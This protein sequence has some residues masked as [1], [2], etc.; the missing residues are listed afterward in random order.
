MLKAFVGK[1]TFPSLSTVLIQRAK[2]ISV[3]LSSRFAYVPENGIIFADLTPV[4]QI[5]KKEKQ[6][7]MLHNIFRPEI[8]ELTK[9]TDLEFV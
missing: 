3:A 5:N 7:V 9:N 2:P 8:V 4:A 6:I 1:Q